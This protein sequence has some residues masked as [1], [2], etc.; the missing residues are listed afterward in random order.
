[1][2]DKY[3]PVVFEN[4]RGEII[5]NDPI[6]IA[7]KRLQD[8]GLLPTQQ[9]DESL[10]GVEYKGLTAAELIALAKERGISTKGLTK[11]SQLRAKLIEADEAAD[12]ADETEEDDEENNDTES[13]KD[14]DEATSEPKAASKKSK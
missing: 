3:Q 6:Y 4:S 5:S 7:Q 13:E 8:A 2:S 11:A 14:S 10:I 9:E 12:E 1:M